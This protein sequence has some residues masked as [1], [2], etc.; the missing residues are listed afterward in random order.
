[1]QLISNMLGGEDFTELNLQVS[2][3]SAGTCLL[4]LKCNNFIKFFLFHSSVSFTCID[5]DTL[6]PK[7]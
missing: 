1:M 6:S 2:F 4:K 7:V 3:I 5:E